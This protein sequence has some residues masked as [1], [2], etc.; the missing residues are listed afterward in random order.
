M[1]VTL[2]MAVLADWIVQ[3][4]L[5]SGWDGAVPIFRMLAAFSLVEPIA[6]FLAV[7]LVAVGNAKALLRWKTITLFILIVSV[8]IG[9]IWGG[10]GV[11]AAYALS[12]VFIRLPGFLYYASRFLPVTFGE[13]TKALVPAAICALGTI[14]ALY[15]LRQFIQIESPAAGLAAFIFAAAIIYSALCLLIKPTRCALIETVDLLKLLT[16]RKLASK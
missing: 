13:F 1:F 9:S 3:L 15:T 2:T 12:G 10:F 16:S 8:G 4:F 7:S 11:V 6:G 14:A 5:G